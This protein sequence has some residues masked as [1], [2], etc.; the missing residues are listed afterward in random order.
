M[1]QREMKRDRI[2][3]TDAAAPD[4]QTSLPRTTQ[5]LVPLNR[6]RRSNVLRT[7]VVPA[8]IRPVAPMPVRAL[9]LVLLATKFAG[10]SPPL[11][12]SSGAGCD[13]VSGRVRTLLPPRL[14]HSEGITALTLQ[15]GGGLLL[16]ADESGELRLWDTSDGHLV[17]AFNLPHL[18]PMHV[19]FDL[20]GEHAWI[21][22]TAGEIGCIEVPAA[23]EVFRDT[24]SS[25]PA[26]TLTVEA[27]GVVT[28]TRPKTIEEWSVASRSGATIHHVPA[29]GGNAIVASPA[30]G[31]FLAGL[32]RV[33]RCVT[34]PGNAE[35]WRVTLPPEGLMSLSMSPGADR[36]GLAFASGRCR[37][38]DA[39]SGEELSDFRI[40][41]G[42]VQA[43]VFPG[44]SKALIVSQHGDLLVRHEARGELSRLRSYPYNAGA[45]AANDDCV[46]SGHADGSIR[47]TSISEAVRHFPESALQ[48][49]YYSIRVDPESRNVL[50]VCSEGSLSWIDVSSGELRPFLPGFR[51]KNRLYDSTVAGR[52][53]FVSD[54]GRLVVGK[55]GDL[56]ES[57]C[58][59]LPGEYTSL[60][61]TEEGDA[62]AL[63]RA[64]GEIE[65]RP[66]SRPEE[67]RLQ[68]AR[69]EASCELLAISA[70][71][72]LLVYCRSAV[73]QDDIVAR[74]VESGTEKWRIPATVGRVMSSC[75][76][77][78][79]AIIA[80]ARSD[81][82][83]ELYS[84]ASGQ[85]LCR[86]S[87][88]AAPT[89]IRFNSDNRGLLIATDDGQLTCLDGL[90]DLRVLWDC[91]LASP[92]TAITEDPSTGWPILG[93][94]DGSLVVV[95]RGMHEGK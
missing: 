93:L 46:A 69:A 73:R 47:L 54:S 51:V 60:V 1:E 55:G 35:V 33:L 9:F 75:I 11:D 59:L 74:D 81:L 78:D 4:R 57:T 39:V 64:G 92:A 26:A 8:A 67:A 22:G 25:I 44:S 62:V 36:I 13:E 76:A 6:A 28:V 53:A 19:A 30:R 40:G 58:E 41:D 23:K 27:P 66:V 10:C 94:A 37:L 20:D 56:P 18:N 48:G 52:Y 15:P 50:A 12:K 7:D 95:S 72:K 21:A 68:N 65:L 85:S 31:I 71:R 2:W 45:L 77:S 90:E 80:L 32:H 82:S 24:S 42:P 84:M 83:V 29:G 87:C 16:A 17:K 63:L 34:F 49:R 5:P 79:G 88:T 86:T 38:L 3:E 70:T 61:W 14:R 89:A 43:V 91:E